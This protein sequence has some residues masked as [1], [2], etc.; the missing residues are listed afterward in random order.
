[1]A[2]VQIPTEESTLVSRIW[3]LIMNR[4]QSSLTL[5]R[6]RLIEFS[7]CIEI[8]LV[9]NTDN[10]KLLI[11]KAYFNFFVGWISSLL[12]LLFSYLVL[13]L[14]VQFLLC[15]LT[16]SCCTL[17]V[18]SL[19]VFWDFTNYIWKSWMNVFVGILVS[20]LLTLVVLCIF[21]CRIVFTISLLAYLQSYLLHNPSSSIF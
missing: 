7:H 14:L 11:L 21:S 10:S 13:V 19:L 18:C 1:M 12:L 6:K 15:P 17:S 20:Y 16:L 4:K 9:N 2:E 8:S 3:I 5:S